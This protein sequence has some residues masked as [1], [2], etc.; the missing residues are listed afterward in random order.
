MARISGTA[1]SVN[2]IE[3]QL[4]LKLRYVDAGSP[5]EVAGLQRGDTIVSINGVSAADM[6][7]SEN[8]NLGVSREGQ[9]I[10][11]VIDRGAGPQAFTVVSKVYS[12]APVTSVAVLP[13]AGGRSAGYLSLKEFISQAETPLTNA[14]S[15]FANAGAT[16]LILDLRY[17]G[18]GLVSTSNAL[19]SLIVDIKNSNEE[20]GVFA[21][22]R[23]NQKQA[24]NYN[25]DFKLRGKTASRYSRVIVLTGSRTCS[26]SEL[27][28]NGLKPYVNVVTIGGTSCG[29]PFGFLSKANCSSTYSAV[30]FESFNRDDGGRY[31]E[32]IPATCAATDDF[33][34]P[35]GVAS[36]KLTTAA[37]SY[38]QTGSCPAVAAAPGRAQALSVS[39]GGARRT[40]EAGERQGMWA[41]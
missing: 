39:R 6:L 41:N 18:G 7:A 38:L 35:L 17:N 23:Y 28:V 36:E 8:Y 16:E 34:G 19:A 4:P 3:Q 11:I 14:F 32:G 40:T 21:K 5:G 2:G 15:T 33:T 31:Y 25:V 24:A 10:N 30:N 12:L 9:Q 26:A 22:L 27:V 20:G 13:L 37:I 29:K 1:L